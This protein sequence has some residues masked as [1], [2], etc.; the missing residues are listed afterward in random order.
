MKLKLASFQ[1]FIVFATISIFIGCV[2]IPS[3]EE[4][5]NKKRTTLEKYLT[6]I[7]AQDFLEK[8]GRNILFVDVRTLEKIKQGMPVGIDA[9]V[10][11][12]F[13]KIKQN[14]KTM[15]YNKNFTHGIA[16]A[17]AKK[18]LNQTNTIILLCRQGN[19]S[20]KA[21]DKLA[22]SGYTNVYTI[23]DGSNGWQKNNLPWNE[24]FDDNKIFFY[25]ES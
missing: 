6:S 16:D 9:Y 11:I 18:S 19:R 5:P 7:E 1:H 3:T 4:L 21:V 12:F 10:P 14:K 13:N 20:A 8:Q 23:T 2:T 24:V 17:L 15:V 22:K 25:H